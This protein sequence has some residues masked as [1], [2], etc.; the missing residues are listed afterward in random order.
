[1]R[2][3]SYETAL[4]TAVANLRFFVISVINRAYTNNKLTLIWGVEFYMRCGAH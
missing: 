3:V 4:Q 1:M 2:Q